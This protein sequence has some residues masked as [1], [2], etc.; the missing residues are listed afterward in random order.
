MSSASHALVN[1]VARASNG[2]SEHIMNSEGISEKVMRQLKR[3]LQPPLTNISV[4][5]TPLE[6][7]AK[8]VEPGALI[9]CPTIIPSIYPG[10][11]THH[12]FTYLN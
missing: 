2:Y 5:W 1:G 3:A 11:I 7:R 4:D 10:G 9:Q 12:E 8:E 6:E